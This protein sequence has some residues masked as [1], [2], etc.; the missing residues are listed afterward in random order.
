MT[1]PIAMRLANRQPVCFLVEAAGFGF[2]FF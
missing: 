1:K 2:L